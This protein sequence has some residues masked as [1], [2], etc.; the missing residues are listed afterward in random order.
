MKLYVYIHIDKYTQIHT[1]TPQNSKPNSAEPNSVLLGVHIS[2]ADATALLCSLNWGL[3]FRVREGIMFGV[4]LW[5]FC[6]GL[7]VKGFN[8]SYHN[9][10][11]I[12]FTID[13]YYG[14]LN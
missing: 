8:L 6:K 3:G 13:P 12:S 1:Y 10:E 14:N 4:P 2:P 7:G 5:G 9:K 11:T